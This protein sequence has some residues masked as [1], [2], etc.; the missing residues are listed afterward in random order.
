VG[1]HS[2]LA[3]LS[4][5]ADIPPEGMRTREEQ[6]ARQAAREAILNVYR[7]RARTG[8]TLSGAFTPAPKA[9]SSDGQSRSS[10]WRPAVGIPGA[11]AFEDLTVE[12]QF[13]RFSTECECLLNYCILV[14]VPLGRVRIIFNH[15]RIG[16]K[17]ARRRPI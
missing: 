9:S 17:S 6:Q 8:A 7:S 3:F 14:L 1:E 11:E 4:A 13:N 2:E 5:F 15:F 12:D 16:D 10:S